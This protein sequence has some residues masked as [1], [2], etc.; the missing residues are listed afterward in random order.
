MYA[1]VF[2]L[3]FEKKCIFTNGSFEMTTSPFYEWFFKTDTDHSK[4]IT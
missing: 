3:R 1:T 4:L 2:Y